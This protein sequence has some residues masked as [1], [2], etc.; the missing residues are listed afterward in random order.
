MI[1]FFVYP[2]FSDDLFDL[3]KMFKRPEK[4]KLIM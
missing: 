4:D 1:I 3:E 2:E